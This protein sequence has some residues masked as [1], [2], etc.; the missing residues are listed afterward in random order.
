MSHA[1]TLTPMTFCHRSKLKAVAMSLN[2]EKCY[3]PLAADA[4]F[5]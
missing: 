5:L 3:V 4:D 1:L 2:G